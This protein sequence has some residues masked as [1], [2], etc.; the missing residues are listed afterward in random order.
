MS[1]TDFSNN[2]ILEND[3]KEINIWYKNPNVLFTNFAE[4][5]PTKSMTFNQKINALTR[6]IIIITILAY[7]FGKSI[8]YIFSG[9]LSILFIYAYSYYCDYK[10][11]F[12]TIYKDYAEA[13]DLVAPDVFESPTTSNP[14][15]NVMI[16]DYKYNPDKKPAM[17]SYNGI[18]QDEINDKVKQSIQEMN[19]DIPDISEKLFRGLGEELTFEQS[20]RQFYSNP[21]TTIPNDQNA[22]ANFCYGNMTSC[23]EGNPLACAKEFTGNYDNL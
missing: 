21:N 13:N 20:M 22:F 11:N 6:L 19:P 1:Y 10:E 8:K 18:V 4:L 7:I 17:P 2:D 12:D 9:I 3:T 14:F 15:S 5:F 23:K 16:S